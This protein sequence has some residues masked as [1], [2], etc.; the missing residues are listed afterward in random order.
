M[1]I[2]NRARKGQNALIIRLI[3][4][5][6]AIGFTLISAWNGLEFYEMLFGLKMAMLITSVFEVARLAC[7]FRFTRSGRNRELIAVIVYV[8][9]ASSCAFSSINSFT[10]KIIRQNFTEERELKAQIH[11]IKRTYSEK[12]ED[13]LEKAER[14]AL[15]RLFEDG[16]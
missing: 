15:E 14:E 11:E 9:A 5:L 2:R 13:K 4:A 8:I 1:Q 16:G 6:L 3:F 12:T 7:L 10:S